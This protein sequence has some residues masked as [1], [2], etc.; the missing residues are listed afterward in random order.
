MVLPRTDWRPST[1]S[2]DAST[3]LTAYVVALLAIPSAMKL[4]PLGSAGAPST[5]LA[6]GAFAWW[7]WFHLQRVEPTT[8]ERQPVRMAMLGWLLIM[9]V[10]YV[11]AMAAPIPADEITPADS[12]LLRLFGMAGILLIA[13]DGLRDL[14]Q[15]RTVLRRLVIGVGLCAALGIVQFATKE[16]WIDRVSIPGLTKPTEAAL[17]LRSGLARPSGTSTHPIEFGV[18]LT[19]TLPIVIAH[20]HRSPTRRWLYSLLVGLVGFAL[21]LSISRSAMICGAAA[22][23]VMLLSWPAATRLRAL[24]FMAVIFAAVYVT[25]PG[26]LG[27]ITRLFTGISDDASVQSRTGSYDIAERFINQS[28]VLGRGF[29]T[30]LPKYWIFDNGYLGLLVEGG[31]VALVGLLVLIA[32]GAWC[33]HQAAR[34]LEDEFDRELARATVAS[35]VAG[36]AGLAFFDTFGFPQSAGCFFLALGMAGALHRLSRS[37]APAGVPAPDRAGGR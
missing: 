20:A 2:V 1:G 9:L 16:L 35:I 19:I 37:R 30:F 34:R 28:P 17:A 14:G 5:V 4:S 26:V 18:V 15:A 11:H 29:G 3:V 8:G 12:G 36:A 25:V 33:A 27:T 23:I 7:A 31:V 10:V 22:M 32:V 13:N 21:I 24:A 6:L